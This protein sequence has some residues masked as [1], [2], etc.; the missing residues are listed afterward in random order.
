MASA[1]YDALAT[2]PY[3]ALSLCIYVVS[4][5]YVTCAVGGACNADMVCV[6]AKPWVM[7]HIGARFTMHAR[8]I[9]ITMWAEC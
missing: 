5:R 7:G 2:F 3:I 4:M 6:H 1:L 9:H 8:K